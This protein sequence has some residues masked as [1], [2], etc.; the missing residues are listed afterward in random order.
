[1]EDKVKKK[2]IKHIAR[3]LIKKKK[4]LVNKQQNLCIFHFTN[5]I[6][7][8]IYVFKASIWPEQLYKRKAKRKLK[9]KKLSK[10][11]EIT[12]QIWGSQTFPSRGFFFQLKFFHASL[13]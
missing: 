11:E 2:I 3:H 7:Y 1:M 8:N 6:W 12:H 4:K 5:N 13:S 9:R 10:L